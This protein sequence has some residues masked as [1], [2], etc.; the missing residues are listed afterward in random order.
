MIGIVFYIFFECLIN[1]KFYTFNYLLA[2][3][4]QSRAVSAF[5]KEQLAQG[6][7]RKPVVAMPVSPPSIHMEKREIW[8]ISF[9]DGLV[10]VQPTFQ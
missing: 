10:F 4:E 6:G 9:G 8:H 2:C 1:F 5:V 7:Y 3:Y